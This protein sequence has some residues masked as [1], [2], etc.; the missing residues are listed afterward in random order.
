MRAIAALLAITLAAGCT[1]S[2]PDPRGVGRDEVLLQ[3]SATGTAEAAPDE[4]RFQTGVSSIGASAGS[5]TEANNRIMNDV[6]GAL[7][8][9]G[10]DKAD[11]QTRQLTVQ[12]ITYGTNKNKFEASNI[13]SV[14]MRDV[15][16]AGAAISATTEA[17][18]N[19][20]SGP[21]LRVADPETASQS[22]YANAYK[23]ARARADAYASAAGMEV[24]RVLVIP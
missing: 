24:A 1:P 13:V 9:L 20:V 8:T 4:A 12:R 6:I 16:K 3:V 19:V 18:A 23:A 5:A 11:I 22:A 14:R 15:E 21:D 7:S 17:G 2:P 10:V